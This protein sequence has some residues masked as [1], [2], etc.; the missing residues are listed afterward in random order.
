MVS[1]TKARIG[2][3]TSGREGQVTQPNADGLQFVGLELAFNLLLKG[4]LGPT[5]CTNSF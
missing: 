2:S 5:L 4:F 3:G 1:G